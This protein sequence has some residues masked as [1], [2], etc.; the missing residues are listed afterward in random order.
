VSFDLDVY[1]RLR[2]F[3]FHLTDSGN[4]SRIRR[5]RSLEST[6]S[7]ATRAGNE[8]ILDKR[9]VAHVSVRVDDSLVSLRDQAPL[10]RGNMQFEEGWSFERFVRHLNDRVFFWPGGEEGPI[11]YGR[12]HFGRYEIESP[13]II[14]VRFDSFAAVNPQTELLFSKCNSGSPRWSRGIPASRGARTFLSPAEA[15]F[16]AAQ[17]V[18]V[19]IVEGARLPD[20]AAVGE[21]LDGPWRALF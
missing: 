13:S 17:V 12:R 9:R 8:H 11:S 20:D 2:P 1:G 15:P 6:T 14:R 10:H 18:E 3:L 5:T 16:V 4:L 19:T 21:K 7:L